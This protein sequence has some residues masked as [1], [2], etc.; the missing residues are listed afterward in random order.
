M[1]KKTVDGYYH[2]PDSE[3]SLDSILRNFSR[4]VD[5]YKYEI[6]ST[7]C[8][9]FYSDVIYQN[10]ELERKIEISNATNYTDYGFT[11]FIYK[12]TDDSSHMSIN[13]PYD[14]QDEQCRF[15]EKAATDFFLHYPEVTAF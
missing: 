14:K 4:L 8:V 15:I 6:V 10:T 11:I 9:K 3:T 1:A 13:I 5:E 2:F 12:L 7:K